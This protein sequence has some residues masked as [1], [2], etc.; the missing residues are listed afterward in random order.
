MLK[1][2]VMKRRA[3]TQSIKAVT[4]KSTLFAI[5]A[6]MAVATTSA[7]VPSAFA[8]D[9]DAE[10]RAVQQQIDQYDS[11]AKKLSKKADTLQNELDKLTAEKQAIQ[12]KV[13]LSQKKYNKLKSDIATNEKKI[14]DNQDALGVT[15]ADM[16][17]DTSISPLE[18]LASSSNIG[19]YV[20]KQTYRETVNDELKATI[21]KIEELKKKLEQQKVDVERVLADQ[22]NQRDALAKKEAER[23]KLVSETRGK[24]SAYQSLSKDAKAKKDKLLEAQRQAIQN[25]Y[26]GGGGGSIAPGSLPAYATWAGS[27]CY[28]DN[29]GYSHRGYNGNGGDPAGY[30]CNQC[31][32]YTAWKMGQ[33][34]GHV[35]S[36]WGNANQWPASAR[37]AGYKVSNTPP[38]P[39][40]RALGVMSPG[41]YGHIVY[42]ESVNS[43]GTLNISQYNEWLNGEGGKYG[44][45]HFSTRS[46]VSPYTYDTYIYL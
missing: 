3:T 8:R 18:M 11:E 17:V 35:P 16:Y 40:Q 2:N 19:D 34:V 5:A 41:A 25:A 30:G 39:G 26:N 24:E 42:V 6:I 46:G 14:A 9:Y 43:D 23:Q 37:A 21:K 45:G 10:I 15:L 22:K 44:Y 32:S 1:S 27:D 31:V 12:A 28:V 38:K 7:V 29:A 4:T 33:V 13:N 36:Y 20:D